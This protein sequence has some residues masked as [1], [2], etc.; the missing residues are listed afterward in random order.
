MKIKAISLAIST[1]LLTAGL[2]FSAQANAKGRLVMYCSATNEMCEAEANAFGEKHDVKV[3]F[4]RNGSGSTFAKI[5]AEK[6]NPQADV[7]Y[8][9]TLDPQSQ[10]G[11]LGLLEAY[12]SPNV[13]QLVESFQDPA[14]VK[15]NLS[16]AIYMGILGFGVNTERLKKL[17]I[18]E[19]PKCWK[20]LTDPRLKGEIQI[21]DPQSSGTAYTAIATFVQLWGEDE[22]FNYFKQLHPN[23]SQ[24]T[25][26]GIAPS[27][28]TARGE[29]TIGI[30]FLHDYAMEKQQ[31][32]QM[33]LIV[34]CEGTGYE[35]GGVSILKGARNMENAKLFVDWALSKEGQEVAWKK[36]N[37]LQ[38]L[39]N[40]T[41]EQSPSAFDP[42]KLN[43]IDYDFEKFG[44]ADERKR[45]I[46]KWVDEIKLAK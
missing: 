38:T 9:G 1:A 31:G 37:S 17:G 34:P 30:G 20:D 6:N 19:I 28:N 27:R 36:G 14:K 41:A 21:A 13:D 32:A 39:T 33:E 4:I 3:S 44:A 29:T 46:S 23:I 43:L 35:L 18:T 40:T 11:E 8:G 24:Y 25:K 12:R 26:S 22:A 42:T 10:A 2:V 45:L 16:S 5:E 15:G 7:W